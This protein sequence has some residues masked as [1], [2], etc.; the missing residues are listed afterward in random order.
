M[1]ISSILNF[2]TA[3]LRLGFLFMTNLNLAA[4]ILDFPMFWLKFHQFS[5]FYSILK[6]KVNFF[7]IFFQCQ[8]KYH[9]IIIHFWHDKLLALTQ[10]SFYGQNGIND[11]AVYVSQHQMD[12]SSLTFPLSNPDSCPNNTF[13]MV[14]GRIIVNHN[15]LFQPSRISD[16]H[17]YGTSALKLGQLEEKKEKI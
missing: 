12:D 7:F 14:S 2:V 17:I 11:Q 3:W 8:G 16:L 10:F 9:I 4:A 15:Y 6:P 5:G 1:H 13:L